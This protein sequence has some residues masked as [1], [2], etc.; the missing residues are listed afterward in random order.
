MVDHSCLPYMIL[1][2]NFFQWI[3]FCLDFARFKPGSSFQN[4]DN[5]AFVFDM[6]DLCD[7]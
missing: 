7:R 3:D 4:I 2:D 6:C 1:V 5:K